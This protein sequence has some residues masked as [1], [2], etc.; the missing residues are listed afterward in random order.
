MTQTARSAASSAVPKLDAQLCFALYTASHRMTRAYRP[1]LDALGLTYVQYLV[2]LILW[3]GAPQSVGTL[4]EALYLDSGTLTPLLKRMEKNGLV[5]RRRDVDDERRVMI[6]LTEH[7]DRLRTRA[8]D[9]SDDVMCRI[10]TSPQQ[11]E[12]LRREIMALVQRIDAYDA[13]NG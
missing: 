11:A 8:R 5:S 4:G 13:A 10:D 7:G 2:M 9:V 6:E 12:T 3:E 1:M